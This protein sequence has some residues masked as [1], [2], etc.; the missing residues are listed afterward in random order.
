MFPARVE[1]LAEEKR[2]I[3]AEKRIHAIDLMTENAR[4]TDERG[5][6]GMTGST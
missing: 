2:E 1:G 3:H 4:R 5:V 6:K